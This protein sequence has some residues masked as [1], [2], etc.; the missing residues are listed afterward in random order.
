M[1]ADRY[2]GSILAY[3]SG[4]SLAAVFLLRAFVEQ[5][6]RSIDAVA[7]SIKDKP[8]PSGDEIG[9]AYKSTLPPDFSGRFPSLCEIYNNLSAAIHAADDSPAIYPEAC[10]MVV[11]HFDARRLFRLDDT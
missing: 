6:W 1:I 5:Y 11:E 10:E 3:Q 7:D 2:S 9:Q 4:Q 8:R